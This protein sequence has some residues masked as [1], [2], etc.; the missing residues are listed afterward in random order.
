[1]TKIDLNINDYDMANIF[2]AYED[3]GVQFFNLYN[4]IFIDPDIDPVLYTTHFYSPTDD[5][6]SLSNKYYKTPKLWW[7]ILIANQISNPF[8]DL[9]AGTKLKILNTTV[10]SEIITQINKKK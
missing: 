4:T 5:W 8:E 7:V 2:N 1:M 3:N 10:L 6:Y 9:M